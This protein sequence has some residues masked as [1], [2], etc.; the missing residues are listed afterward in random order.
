MFIRIQ[1]YSVPY[2]QGKNEKYLVLSQRLLFKEAAIYDPYRRETSRNLSRTKTLDLVDKDIKNN[3]NYIT[4]VQ[5]F[6]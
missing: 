3:R 1:V 6:K 4:Y 2:L 5:N